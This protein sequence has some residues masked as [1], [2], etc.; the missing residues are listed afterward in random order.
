MRSRSPASSYVNAFE[1]FANG[2]RIHEFLA[3]MH[4]EVFGGREGK[5]LTVGEMPGVTTE[6]AV[7]YTDPA[8]GEVDMVFQFE[9]VSIDHGG[10]KWDY[11]GLDRRAAEAEPAPLAGGAR[12]ARLEQPLL[13]QPRPAPR[14][15]ALRRRRP[16][17]LGRLG[18]GARHDPPRHARHAVR[19]PG[20]GARDDRT[21]PSPRPTSSRTWS[22][23]TAG[24]TWCARGLDQQIELRSM[25]RGRRGTTPARRCSGTRPSR[26]A[27]RPGTPWFPVNPNRSWLNAAAQVDDPASVFAHYRDL[28]RA[29]ARARDLRRRRLRRR[30]RERPRPVGVHRARPTRSGCSC[31]ANCS[32]T[33]RALELGD[34]WTGSRLLLG[35][36]PGV[37]DVLRTGELELAAW[38]ARIYLLG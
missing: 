27:S 11:I 28:I 4:R 15:L 22:P 37:D 25:A 2:P 6:E 36:H 29:A 24:R 38:E 31:I 23:S 9:H 16:R 7:L 33:P 34:G 17:V 32:R 5:F 20:G 12:R 13:G 26:P 19:V 18:Q 3:E 10:N 1:L 35:T 14:R 30:A 8:R 21:S